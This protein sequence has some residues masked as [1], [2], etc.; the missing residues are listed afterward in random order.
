M[1]TNLAGMQRVVREDQ[2]PALGRSKSILDEG[3]IQIL[4]P[5]VELVAN[6]GMADVREVNANLVFAAGVRT[7]P[8]E[9]ERT[10][11]SGEMAFDRK[12][13][14]RGG[15]VG[16]DLVLDGDT[17]VG[18][19]TER[20]DDAAVGFGDGAVDDGEVLLLDGATFPGAAQAAGGGVGL[21]HDHDAAGFAVEAVDELRMAFGA[22]VQAHAADEAR[23]NIPLG[24]MADEAG[25]LVED[26]QVGVFAEDL[27]QLF[28][29]LIGSGNPRT[30]HYRS[31]AYDGRVKE[32]G[33]L[34][35][36]ILLMA[37]LAVSRIPGLLPQNF[38]AVY[39]LVFCAGVYFPRRMAWWLPLA[40]LL[41]SD[42]LLNWYYHAHY[43]TPLFS[44]E[45]IGNYVAY[46]SLIWLGQRFNRK[47]SFVA[48]LG[49]GILGAILFYLI[50][51]TF[52]WLFN[53]FNN[54]EYTKT[55]AGW[56]TA[57]TSGTKGYMETWKFFR[58]TFGSTGLFTGLFVGAM[59][60]L[61]AME[62]EEDEEEAKE[63]AEQPEGEP[64]EAKA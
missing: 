62:P 59:K 49:G 34:F 19:G 33:N 21:R 1:K 27:E 60:L 5:A 48:L 24:G 14:L 61:E 47:S 9:R 55:L 51:N 43:Q 31:Q 13:G 17:A 42:A 44:P 53:P 35:L 50:T 64:E 56:I 20:S 58:N 23:V 38:S 39:G 52:S 4:V 11:R 46:L 7:D 3:E 36:P 12:V 63:G 18:I 30:C 37:V 41:V 54:P 6:D 57:L 40:T 26:Q 29:A 8:Q 15:A 28:H 32:K 25:R 2:L 45:L 10:L 16:S 22:E